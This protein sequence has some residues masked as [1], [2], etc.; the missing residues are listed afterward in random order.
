MSVWL[1]KGAPPASG[2]PGWGAPRCAYKNFRLRGNCAPVGPFQRSFLAAGRRLP[3]S[4]P[5][6]HVLSCRNVKVFKNSGLFL[7][8]CALP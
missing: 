7:I 6:L 4:Q 2:W 5:C 8:F 1:F 3:A